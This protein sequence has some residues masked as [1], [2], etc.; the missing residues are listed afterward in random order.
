[1]R[2]ARHAGRARQGDHRPTYEPPEHVLDG[3][4]IY[5]TEEEHRA[6][7]A[8]YRNERNFQSSI[9]GHDHTTEF[10]DAWRLF[11][12]GG[13]FELMRR[14]CVGLATALPNT[15]SF[16]SDFCILK[17]EK[18]AYRENLLDLSLE[19][20]FHAKQFDLLGSL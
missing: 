7:I 11:C 9:D 20:I 13:R 8:A 19:G 5:A 14:F 18:D 4:R 1:K 10:N 3:R 2:A 6:L 16:E 15:T 12:A 17:W